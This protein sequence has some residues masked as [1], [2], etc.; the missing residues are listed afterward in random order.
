LRRLGSFDINPLAI[1]LLDSW[2]AIQRQAVLRNLSP[3]SFSKQSD[4][5]MDLAI[6]MFSLS[7]TPQVG[8]LKPIFKS[9]C[10]NCDSV[11]GSFSSLEEVPFEK[12]ICKHCEYEYSPRS[13][14]D[15]IEIVFE[16]CLTPEQPLSSNVENIINTRP[17][18]NRGKEQSLR[19]SDIKQHPSN[20]RRHLIS[21]LDSRY[22]AA[23]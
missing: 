17:G 12:I 19:V 2:L 1:K 9:I 15:Q 23:Q 14:E 22:E 6:D 4:V 10:P 8:V 18:G 7:S 20:A 21:K 16:R 11:N 5:D 13:R 3:M